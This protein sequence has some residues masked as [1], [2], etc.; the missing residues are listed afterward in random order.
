MKREDSFPLFSLLLLVLL[1]LLLV[2]L[3][4]FR[5]ALEFDS[6]KGV[7][8]LIRKGIVSSMN[9]MGIRLGS[10]GFDLEWIRDRRINVS[11]S[12]RCSNTALAT[13]QSQYNV[14]KSIR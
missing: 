5:S 9:E 6:I 3:V 4:Y 8:R 14:T 13:I 2:A 7:R 11:K 1:L 10:G 12:D